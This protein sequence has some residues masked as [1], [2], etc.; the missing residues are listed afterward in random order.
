M[1]SPLVGFAGWTGYEEH[2]PRPRQT[3]NEAD[4]PGRCQTQSR[5]MILGGGRGGGMSLVTSSAPS[6]RSMA[7]SRETGRRTCSSAAVKAE[8]PMPWPQ[9]A[10]ASRC[11]TTPSSDD[12]RSAAADSC[13][14]ALE[15][16]SAWTDTA[17]SK[18][19]RTMAT[20]TPIR[21]DQRIIQQ[22]RNFS[23]S[24]RSCCRP[25]AGRR[26]FWIFPP[27][28]RMRRPINLLVPSRRSKSVA[29]VST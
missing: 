16:C 24:I 14:G 21:N 6:A 7:S 29:M 18:P 19:A 4:L 10:S 17:G 28:C 22:A 9:V 20:L 25:G 8:Q 5:G 3:G 26:P 15:Y 23:A 27:G 13:A 1:N 11:L 12:A 2:R